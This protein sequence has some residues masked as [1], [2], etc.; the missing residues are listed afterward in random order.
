MDWTYY[1][2]P[3]ST[4][5]VVLRPPFRIRQAPDVDAK[6]GDGSG[7]P[8]FRVEDQDGHFLALAPNVPQAQCAVIA[9]ETV[10][11]SGRERG[12][13]AARRSVNAPA[14]KRQ[15]AAQLRLA[16]SSDPYPHADA[17]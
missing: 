4:G 11:A 17:Q 12:E 10:Y 6:Q 9:F 16:N 2:P 3:A 8:A 1:P 15:T 13:E 14:I 5:R 7:I